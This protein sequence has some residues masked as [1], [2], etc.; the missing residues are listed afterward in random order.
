VQIVGIRVEIGRRTRT[1]EDGLFE[2]GIDGAQD[3][4]QVPQI[5]Q[6]L[7]TYL[8]PIRFFRARGEVWVNDDR[9]EEGDLA[10][11]RA[12]GW[13]LGIVGSGR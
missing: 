10:R 8:W 4:K 9:A 5:Y 11:G 1:E 12:V 7:E 3:G 6:R 2:A 13:F